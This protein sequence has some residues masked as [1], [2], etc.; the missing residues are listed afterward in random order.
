MR[1]FA[2]AAVLSPPPYSGAAGHFCEVEDTADKCGIPDVSYCPTVLLY[3][4]PEIEL[5]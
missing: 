3:H 2:G 4:H 1:H 5:A